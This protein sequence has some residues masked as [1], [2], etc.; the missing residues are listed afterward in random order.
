M[1][2]NLRKSDLR[3][4]CSLGILET[5]IKLVSGQSFAILAAISC[6]LIQDLRASALVSDIA[7]GYAIAL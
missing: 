5:P 1:R 7:N 4:G 2:A 3:R 6:A